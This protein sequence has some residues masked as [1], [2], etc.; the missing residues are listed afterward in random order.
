M[1]L[2]QW[3]N[4]IA[5]SRN[6]FDEEEFPVGVKNESEEID[7]DRR[8]VV[9]RLD[10]DGFMFDWK[11]SASE[12]QS[13]RVTVKRRET[14]PVEKPAAKSARDLEKQVE[15]LQKQLDVRRVVRQKFKI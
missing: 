1:A 12:A 3:Q 11:R 10:D 6:F 7:F 2:A 13:A 9:G 15:N 4:N 8:D 14:K 5:C